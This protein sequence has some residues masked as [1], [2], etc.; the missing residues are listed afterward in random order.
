MK[1]TGE[2]VLVV[3]VAVAWNSLFDPVILRQCIPGCESV[4]QETDILYKVTLVTSIGPLRAKFS[5][6]LEMVNMQPPSTCQLIFEGTG[7]AVGFAKGTSDVSLEE[8]DGG[9]KLLFSADT[10]ISG[11]LSQIGSR[12]ID[13]VAKK[14]SGEFFDKFESLMTASHT[15]SGSTPLTSVTIEAAPIK[16]RNF[17]E[18]ASSMVR[19]AASRE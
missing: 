6:T 11:K 14:L 7:G 17:Y 3:P 1:I 12:L 16:K 19:K 18:A 5:G 4:V 8:W 10:Q 2:R 15:E 9:T 13:S